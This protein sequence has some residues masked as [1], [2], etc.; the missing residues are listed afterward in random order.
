MIDFFN[1]VSKKIEEVKSEIQKE[2]LKKE[3]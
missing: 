2:K 3:E 1:N